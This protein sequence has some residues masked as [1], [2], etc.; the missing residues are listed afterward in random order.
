M[1]S[2]NAGHD[3]KLTSRPKRS[4]W[5]KLLVRGGIALLG[6]VA[7]VEGVSSFGYSNTLKKLESLL[8]SDEQTGKSTRIDELPAIGSGWYS[9]K[10]LEVPGSRVVELRWPSLVKQYVLQLRVSKT[11]GEILDFTTGTDLSNSSV[12]AA[13]KLGVNPLAVKPVPQGGFGLDTVRSNHIL[14]RELARQSILMT[15]REDFGLVTRD[16]I[17]QE[18]WLADVQSENWPF[19]IEALV[20]SPAAV[21]VRLYRKTPKEKKPLFEKAISVTE[22]TVFLELSRHAEMWSGDEFV[23]V[24][25]SAGFKPKQVPG[26]Q[27]ES[28]LSDEVVKW[29]LAPDPISHCLALRRL[30]QQVQDEGDSLAVRTAIARNYAMLGSMTEWHWGVGHKVFKARAML[31]AD[32]AVRKWPDHA[33]AFWTRA[34]VRGFVGLHQPGLD[35]VTKARE[36]R[37]W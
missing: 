7:I 10:E 13:T 20:Q 21:G 25:K 14:F 28:K 1:S 30:H 34:F 5:E 37:Y 36:R 3:P 33:E 8:S 23:E 19:E 35:D 26:P 32:R 12:A 4:T 24:L 18:A 29:S 9:Q 2:S 16:D 22:D 31:C 17:L 27:T 15:A 11:G 6:I